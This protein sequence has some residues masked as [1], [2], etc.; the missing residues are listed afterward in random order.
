MHAATSTALT[1]KEMEPGQFHWIL[2]E[3]E[4]SE[5]EMSMV[6]APAMISEHYANADAAWVAGYLALRARLRNTA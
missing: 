5:L 6:Y 4:C 1:V 3:E 2:L